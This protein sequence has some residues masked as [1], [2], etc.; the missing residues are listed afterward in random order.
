MRYT[1]AV[2]KVNKEYIKSKKDLTQVLDIAE[3]LQ[4]HS[5]ANSKPN[6]MHYWAF[7]MSMKTGTAYKFSQ[8]NTEKLHLD[9]KMAHQSCMLLNNLPT[10]PVDS[11]IINFD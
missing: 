3:S 7:K 2:L 8:Q 6:E 11:E 1:Y 10:A 9:V 5:L 4:K